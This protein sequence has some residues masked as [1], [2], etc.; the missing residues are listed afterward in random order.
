ML[1]PRSPIV[2]CSLTLGFTAC[3]DDTN[4]AQRVAKRIM[5]LST[6]TTVTNQV[7]ILT[8]INIAYKPNQGNYL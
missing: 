2:E 5:G 1:N 7:S 4:I 6:V 3:Q 8:S